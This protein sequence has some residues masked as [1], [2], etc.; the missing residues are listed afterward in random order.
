MAQL[1]A[2]LDS[3]VMIEVY[4]KRL[5]EEINVDSGTII[6]D[7]NQIKLNN[8]KSESGQIAQDISRNSSG[9]KK[10]S[11]VGHKRKPSVQIDQTKYLRDQ[12]LIL[13]ILASSPE[14]FNSIADRFKPNLFS[15]RV[16]KTLAGKII[17]AADD[18]QLSV[19]NLIFWTDE[20]SHDIEN[21]NYTKQLMPVLMALE[22][23]DVRS[24]QELLFDVL[25]KLEQ[26]AMYIR[27]TEIL[28]A[29]NDKHLSQEQRKIN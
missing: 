17:S 19:Q 14:L 27:Q 1:L 6:Y 23:E 26:Y 13:A 24:D 28:D 2:K 5:S 20:L 16:L 11:I 10:R 4:A 3:A 29:I 25:L 7:V 18:N 9:Y 21:I 12:W 22:D 8:A 15:N